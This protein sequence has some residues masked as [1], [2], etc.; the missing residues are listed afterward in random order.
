M[1]IYHPFIHIVLLVSYVLIQ[2]SHC[3]ELQL[4]MGSFWGHASFYLILIVASNVQWSSS[5]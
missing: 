4:K 1:V 2:F 5:Y 3:K